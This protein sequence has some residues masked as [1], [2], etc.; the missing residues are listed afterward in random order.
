MQ[1]RKIWEIKNVRDENKLQEMYDLGVQHVQNK[2]EDLIKYL[3]GEN[4]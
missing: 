2:I 4:K 1:R 3:K